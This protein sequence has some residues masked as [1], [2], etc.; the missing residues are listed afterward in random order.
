MTLK[1]PTILVLL[2]HCNV[3]NDVETKGFTQIF[4]LHYHNL[5][6]CNNVLKSSTNLDA[7]KPSCYKITQIRVLLSFHS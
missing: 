5:S 7:L 3:K 4:W 1:I 6:M 2:N